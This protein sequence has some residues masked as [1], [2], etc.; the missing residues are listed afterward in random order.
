MPA[1]SCVIFLTINVRLKLIEQYLAL[2]KSFFS[3][4]GLKGTASYT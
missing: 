1:V 4:V 3:V 2:Y